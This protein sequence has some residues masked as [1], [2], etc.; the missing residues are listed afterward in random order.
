MGDESW[1]HMWLILSGNGEESWE[2]LCGEQGPRRDP[3]KTESWHLLWHEVA[4]HLIEV[5]QLTS[6][7]AGDDPYAGYSG[8]EPETN[9]LWAFRRDNDETERRKT[10]LE[11]GIGAPPDR[12]D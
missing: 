7:Q 12:G 10:R 9:P 5:G 2:C 11:H 3:L 8:L 4:D 1:P 6:D